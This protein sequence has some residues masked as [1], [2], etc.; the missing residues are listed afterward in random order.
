LYVGKYISTVDWL[1]LV[2]GEPIQSILIR[3]AAD[4]KFIKTLGGGSTKQFLGK[5]IHTK[6]V[7]SVCESTP[8]RLEKNKRTR[9][10]EEQERNKRQKTE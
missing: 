7:D 8:S 9:D 4:A 1:L 3:L 10:S 5:Y 2:F 6:T